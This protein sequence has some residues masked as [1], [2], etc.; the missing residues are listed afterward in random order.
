MIKETY[1]IDSLEGQHSLNEKRKL[2]TASEISK[3]EEYQKGFDAGY[4]YAIEKHRII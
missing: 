2:N 3:K 1:E 4:K